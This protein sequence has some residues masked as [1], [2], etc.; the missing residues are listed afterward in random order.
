[1]TVQENGKFSLCEVIVN[2]WGQDK[3]NCNHVVYVTTTVP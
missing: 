1:M 3:V 2:L